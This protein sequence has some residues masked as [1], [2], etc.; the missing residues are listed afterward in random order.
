[1]FDITSP[2][3][4]IMISLEQHDILASR[5]AFGQKLNT[6]GFQIMKVRQFHCLHVHLG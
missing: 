3:D 5:Q 4:K 6:I 2:K 1:M